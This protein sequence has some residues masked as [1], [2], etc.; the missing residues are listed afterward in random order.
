MKLKAYL[1]ELVGAFFLTAAVSVSLTVG[2][3]LATPVVAGITLGLFVYTVG[4]IS[5]AH[6]NPAVTIGLASVKKIGLKDAGL[7]VI[8]QIAGALLAMLV[9]RAL[10]GA[11]TV[12]QVSNA[13]DLGIVEAIGAF[14]LVFGVSS[15]VWAKVDDDVSG[16][17]IGGSLMLGIMLTGGLSNGVLN[18]AVAIGI[19]SI[20]WMYLLA[21]VLGGVISAWVYKFLAGK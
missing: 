19:G 2:T 20:S 12:L 18:P 4:A 6:L 7:Y 21:P 17:V 3:P 10:T 11:E 1:A 8:F 15:V 13:W 9:V 14:I 16:L 5:G